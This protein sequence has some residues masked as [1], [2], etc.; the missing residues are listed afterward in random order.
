MTEKSI[1][2]LGTQTFTITFIKIGGCVYKKLVLFNIKQKEQMEMD[3]R[4][5]FLKK[6]MEIKQIVC[7][8]N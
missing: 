4:K 7:V 3:T 8:Y 2:L 1:Q 6:N 5:L